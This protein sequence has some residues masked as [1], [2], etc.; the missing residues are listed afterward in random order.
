MR[1]VAPITAPISFWRPNLERA[2]I[3]ASVKGQR[4]VVDSYPH[5]LRKQMGA[6]KLPRHAA[7]YSLD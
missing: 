1:N 7:S 4:T 5:P 3:L 2:L 6:R